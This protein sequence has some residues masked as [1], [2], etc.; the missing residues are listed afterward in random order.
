MMPETKEIVFGE[1]GGLVEVLYAGAGFLLVRKQ[2][3]LEIA[4]KLELPHCDGR[5]GSPI[6][7]YFQPLVRA[8]GDGHWYLGEDYA[9]CERARRCGYSILADT[10]IRLGHIGNYPY[11]WEDAGENPRRFGS[12]RFRLK[13]R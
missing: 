9:F 7:P 10:T 5:F 3:Y 11:S 2:V 4:H 13:S 12:Y 6:T 8:D 1:N